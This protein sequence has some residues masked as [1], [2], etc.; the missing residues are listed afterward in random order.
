MSLDERTFFSRSPMDGGRKAAPLPFLLVVFVP[1]L[2]CRSDIVI[3]F[4]LRGGL[5]DFLCLPSRG[6]L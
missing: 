6:W 1:F 3:L 2:G 4:F 5:A